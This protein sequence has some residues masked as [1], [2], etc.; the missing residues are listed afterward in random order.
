MID[1]LFGI[2]VSKKAIDDE[3]V[4]ESEHAYT[5]RA[6]GKRVDV[7]KTQV[8]EYDSQEKSIVSTKHKLFSTKTERPNVNVETLSL[9]DD[10]E[11]GY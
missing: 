8:V 2:D 7:P 6:P 9:D 3:P 10:K 5:K 4:K 1:S 11:R